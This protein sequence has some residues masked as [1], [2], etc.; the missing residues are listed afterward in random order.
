MSKEKMYENLYNNISIEKFKQKEKRIERKNSIMQMI[1]SA[2]VCMFCITSMVYAKS[3]SEKIVYANDYFTGNAI[4]KAINE[5]YIEKPEDKKVDVETEVQDTYTGKVYDNV[6]T[7]VKVKDFMMDDF[8]LSITF[9]I[10]FGENVDDIIK[11]KDMNSIF[12]SGLTILDENKNILFNSFTEK[13][14][15]EFL[16]E[17]NMDLDYE[18][19]TDYNIV[20]T[21]SNVFTKSVNGNKA[22]VVYN[23][24]NDYAGFPKS[25]KLFLSCNEINVS[26]DDTV[27]PG[28]GEI[29]FNEDWKIDLD[30]PEKMYAR[31]NINYVAKTNDKDVDIKATMYDTGFYLDCKYNVHQTNPKPPTSEKLE[32]LK[33]LPE[34][35][36]LKND[37]DIFNY[38]YQ[39]LEKTE[40]YKEYIE[41]T[42][43]INGLEVK[44]TNT[45]GEEIEKVEGP[46]PMGGKNLSE[47]GI[48]SFRQLYD[49]TKSDAPDVLVLNLNY[50]GKEQKIELVKEEK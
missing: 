23:I 46:I 44:L 13:E 2:L 15:L 37:M 48:M 3:I 43:K 45:D 39:E 33:S 28:T 8:N 11:V 17:N 31:E 21:G 29:M 24:Y 36:P 35:N 47:D 38:C 20:N 1:G 30:V 50:Q 42:R 9:E 41:A 32:F 22:T 25:K 49:V 40:E 18:N 10:E 26:K 7:K 27:Y 14:L 16:K 6:E 12:L 19:T 4:G 5:G 34:D